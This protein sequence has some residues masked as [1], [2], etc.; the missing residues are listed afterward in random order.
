M[1]EFIQLTCWGSD[2][3]EVKT[4]ENIHHPQIEFQAR[5]GSLALEV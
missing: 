5:K 3:E 1:R 4:K 2:R